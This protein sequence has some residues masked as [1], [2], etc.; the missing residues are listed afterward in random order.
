MSYT[1]KQVLDA[2]RKVEHPEKKKNIVDLQMVNDIHIDGNEISFTLIFEKSNDPFIKSLRQACVKTVKESLGDDAKIEGNIKVVARQ[3]VEAK[4]MDTKQGQSQQDILSLPGVKNIIAVASGKGGVGKSMVAS[5]LAVSLAQ[6]G[7][8]VALVDADIYG[9]SVPM[10]FDVVNEKPQATDVDG[11][12]KVL[13]IEKYGIKLLSIG[14][15][16][17]PDQA[18]IWRGPMASNALKQLFTEAQWGEADYLI[19]DLPPGTGDIHLTLVQSLAIT[20]AV[21]VTTPQEMALADARKAVGMFR[22]EKIEVP[23]LGVIE[24]MSYFSPEDARDKKYYLFGKKGGEKLA[25]ETNIPLLG[26]IPVNEK[27][28]QSGEAGKPQAMEWESATG[29][30]FQDMAKNLIEQVDIRNKT[31]DPTTAVE[32][33]PNAEGCSY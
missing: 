7:A 20:G 28:M 1:E 31:M 4:K 33:D 25:K 5:N 8:K 6:T 24:N 27:I 12:T 21:I 18:L 2:L 14:F 9:P 29:K 22:Q 10:M 11:K 19:L 17:D 3:K 32:I 16:V 26:E 15:F 23:V 30:A 13:P